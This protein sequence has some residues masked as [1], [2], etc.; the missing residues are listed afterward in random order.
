MPININNHIY[1]EVKQ[2]ISFNEEWDVSKILIDRGTS[3]LISNFMYTDLLKEILNNELNLNVILGDKNKEIGFVYTDEVNKYIKMKITDIV[4]STM[5]KLNSHLLKF[6]NERNDSVIKIFLDQ[7]KV[8]IDEKLDKYNNNNTINCS[9][10][11]IISDIYEQKKDEA[12][13]ISKNITNSNI[14]SLGY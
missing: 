9:V 8:M 11:N 14:G 7:L 5:N 10:K 1:F 13:K 4:D 2:P 12:I 3:I 6:I